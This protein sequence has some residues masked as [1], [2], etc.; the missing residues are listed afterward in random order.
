MEGSF[1]GQKEWE[2]GKWSTTKKNKKLLITKDKQNILKT[3]RGK[4][5]HMTCRGAKI[6]ITAEFLSETMQIRRQR[7]DIFNVLTQSHSRI[8]Y[9]EQISFENEGEMKTFSDKWKLRELIATSPPLQEMW[10]EVNEGEIWIYTQKMKNTGN[11]ITE[12]KYKAILSL[13]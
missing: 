3:A 10:K 2:K 8:L 7:C 4:T 6:R 9:S 12:S 13:F 1:P 11:R 5:I